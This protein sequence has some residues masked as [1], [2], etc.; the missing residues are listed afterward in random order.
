MT[1]KRKLVNKSKIRPE[2]I[3]QILEAATI[4]FK[5]GLY[6]VSYKSFKIV[7]HEYSTF[8]EPFSPLF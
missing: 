2:K 6:M 4:K 5:I 1:G 7:S 3:K 8:C